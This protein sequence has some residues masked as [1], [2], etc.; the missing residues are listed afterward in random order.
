MVLD[1]GKGDAQKKKLTD[2]LEKVGLRLNKTK[3][4]ITIHVQK[5]GGI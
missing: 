4:N 2:E 3:P 5:T 1:A